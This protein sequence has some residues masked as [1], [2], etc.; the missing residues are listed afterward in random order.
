MSAGEVLANERADVSVRVSGLS[1][2]VDASRGR[3]DDELLD[4]ANTVVEH[5]NARLRLSSE[6]T[7]VALAGATGSGKSSLFN[8]LSDLEIAGVGV[9]RPTTSWALACAWGPE[10]ASDILDWIGIPARQQVSR[11]SMLDTSSD[12]TNLRG[13]VLLDLPDH[14][15]TEVAHH[16]EVDRLVE[17]A[18]LL[19]WVLDPQKYA[20]AAIHERYLKPYATHS[21]VM[22]VVLNQI[23][24]IPADKRDAAVA[25]V[26]RLLVNDGVPDPIV[27]TTS[28]VTGQGLDDLRRMLVKRIREKQAARGRIGADVRP[29]AE[30]LAAVSGTVE[31]PVIGESERAAFRDGLA[32]S[33]GVPSVVELVR[34]IAVERGARMTSWPLMRLVTRPRTDPGH[35]IGGDGDMSSAALVHASMPELRAQRGHADSAVRELAENTTST[36]TQPWVRAVRSATTGRSGEIVDAVDHAV[37]SAD[38]GLTKPPLWMRIVNIVQW[39]LLL[40]VVVGLAWWIA[41][42]VSDGTG[43]PDPEVGGVS[44]PLIVAG[45]ALVVGIV[46]GIVS[47]IAVGTSAKRRAREADAALRQSIARVA[48]EQIIA[49]VDK[50]LHAY[51]ATRAGL[52]AA[53]DGRG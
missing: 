41:V 19:V 44:V 9:K 21:D 7:I 39:L 1:R 52:R 15:S 2:A 24:L 11:M 27:L 28:T 14:D 10:G 46:L 23:D 36:L 5:A 47:R 4:P 20:D 13:L 12:D 34:S 16:L 31:T 26:R 32:D 48:D 35:R 38:L 17:Y 42:T 50:E 18:D 53:L 37:E 43:L 51:D 3:L 22:I 30:Q 8:K 40:G 6:H 29:V 33:V 25:D 45:G 49:P